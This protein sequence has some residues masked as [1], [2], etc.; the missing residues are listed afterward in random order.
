MCHLKALH[1]EGGASNDLLWQLSGLTG[2]TSLQLGNGSG[3]WYDLG[4]L[5]PLQGFG[6]LEKLEITASTCTATSLQGLESLDRLKRV[7]IRGC[8]EL[9]S[10]QGLGKGVTILV[11][12]DAWG[13]EALAGIESAMSLQELG[14][15]ECAVTSLAPLAELTAL[16]SVKVRIGSPD[17]P[18]EGGLSSLKGLEGSKSCLESYS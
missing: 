1:Y 6:N 10:L 2:L 14:L 17:N 18:A 5:R 16:R 3:E 9:V 7:Y 15:C 12:E 8:Y 13:L 4:S 11:L